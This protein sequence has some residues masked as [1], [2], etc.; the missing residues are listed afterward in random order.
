MN[1]V[2]NPDTVEEI[3]RN[4]AFVTTKSIMRNKY[5]VELTDEQAWA[6]VDIDLQYSQLVQYL[7][8]Q[9][10]FDEQDQTVHQAAND[11]LSRFYDG[12]WSDWEFLRVFIGQ[13]A[14]SV[15][16]LPLP[17]ILLHWLTVIVY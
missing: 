2:A 14:T 10:I 11:I 16:P 1:V 5:G 3:R 8:D 17:D 7:R 12:R 9:G 6:L 15:S 13:S 4:N